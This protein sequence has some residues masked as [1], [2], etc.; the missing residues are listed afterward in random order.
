MKTAV[1][2]LLLVV[3]TFAQAPKPVDPLDELRNAIKILESE[4]PPAMPGVPAS[5]VSRRLE[6][7]NAEMMELH[8]IILAIEMIK[9]A[10]A[11]IEAEKQKVR[12]VPALPTP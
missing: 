7:L 3:P 6:K 4:P 12:V 2:L 10:I 1:L 8:K 9:K 11:Q 5:A